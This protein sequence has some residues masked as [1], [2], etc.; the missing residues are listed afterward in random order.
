MNPRVV[1]VDDHELFRAGVR[2]EL[3]GLVDV[4]GE[5]GTVEEAVERIEA[6]QPDVVL[7]DVHMPGGGG[8][9]VIRRAA[10]ADPA[11]RFLALSVSDDPE[12]VIAVIRAGARGYVTKTVSGVELADAIRRVREDDAVFSPRLAGFVLDAFAGSLPAARRPRARPAHDARARGPAPTS[13]AATSTRRSRCGSASRS[14]R[15]RRTCRR[16]C[17]SS[18]SRTG[19]SSAAGRWSGG[20][21]ESPCRAR[22]VRVLALPRVAQL[23]DRPLLALRHEDRVVAEALRATTLGGDPALE[24]ARPPHL[25]AVGPDRDQLADVPGAPILDAVELAEQAVER[26]V[27]AG[28]A[29]RVQPGPTAERVDREARVLAEH[30]LAGRGRAP[31]RTAPSRARSRSASRPSSGGNSPHAEQLDR[32]PRQRGPQLVELVR[33]GRGQPRYELQRTARTSSRSASRVERARGSL[34]E[35][36]PQDDEQSVAGLLE[37][38]RLDVGAELLDRGEQRPRARAA[39]QLDLERPLLRTEPREDLDRPGSAAARG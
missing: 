13:P 20:S 30:P 19:T 8:L 6:E 15:S 34:G 4:V 9:E 35:G 18:S 12:D 37:L 22:P 3:D 23:G 39:C 17:G 10:R 32:P 28:P 38:E 24:R 33:V 14:R 2:S 5:A 21:T 1:I 29:R 7:L 36:R 27:V 16:C 31:G 11:T 26:I 25:V